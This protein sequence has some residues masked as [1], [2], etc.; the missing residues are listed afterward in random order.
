MSSIDCFWG[1]ER[2]EEVVDLS[3]FWLKLDCQATCVS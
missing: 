2:G 1:I 3:S